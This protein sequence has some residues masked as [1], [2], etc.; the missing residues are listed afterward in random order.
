MALP[1]TPQFQTSL[2]NRLPR[3]PKTVTSDASVV[4]ELFTDIFTLQ[5]LGPL[6]SCSWLGGRSNIF[7]D[8]FQP[9][10]AGY[11]AKVRDDAAG[12]HQLAM[13]AVTALHHRRAIGLDEEGDNNAVYCFLQ[14]GH[15]L[16]LYV[17]SMN[18]RDKSDGELAPG[19]IVCLFLY[20]HFRWMC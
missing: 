15:I 3:N 7:E 4:V 14:V 1:P 6:R 5:S 19:K 16:R 12:R 13:F 20:R 17:A 18:P 9:L 8:Q 2:N 11:E 10:L